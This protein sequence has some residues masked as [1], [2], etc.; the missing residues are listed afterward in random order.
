[1]EYTLK[2]SQQDIQIISQALGELPLKM[3]VNVF[4]KIQ[5]QALE[6]ES[7]KS[8]DNAGQQAGNDDPIL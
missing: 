4:G 3:V 6:Q 5:Q 8:A 2:L 7:V 1:M